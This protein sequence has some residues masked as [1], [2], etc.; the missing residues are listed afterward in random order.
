[1]PWQRKYDFQSG[2]KISSNQV[3]EE[4]NQLIAAVN[5]VQSDDNSK[6]VD[7]RSKAQML[8]ITDDTGDYKLK[9]TNTAQNFLGQ[10]LA[11]VVGLATVYCIAGAVNNPS[12]ADSV[13][14]TAYVFG[15]F[16]WVT[17]FDKAGGVF[18]NHLDNGTWKGWNVQ[19]VLWTGAA[20]PTSTVTPTKPLS[21][22]KNGWIL[23]WS[24]Y[25]AAV[26]SNDYDV[27]YSFIPKSS[28]FTNGYQTLFIVPNYLT[29]SGLNYVVKKLRVFDNRLE[30]F[31]ENNSNTTG[32][33]DV[34]LRNVLEW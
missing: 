29:A 31:D 15:N 30:A 25:D 9:V 24:D 22:C 23:V 27:V 1:M 10:I 11:D 16:G 18:T 12:A 14:G 13:R 28:P 7:L 17:V 2:T 26:G 33:N 5:Q 34:C 20:Y 6:D 32:T 19:P 4:F 8:K 21:K 3:D